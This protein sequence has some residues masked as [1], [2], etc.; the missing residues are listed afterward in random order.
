MLHVFDKGGFELQ[1]HT[2]AGLV[3]LKMTFKQEVPPRS[4]KLQP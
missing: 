1:R 3:E 2:S 4:Q